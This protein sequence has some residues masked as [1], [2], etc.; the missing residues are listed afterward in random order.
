MGANS[1][2]RLLN[3]YPEV[4]QPT[5]YMWSIA[6]DVLVGTA[7]MEHVQRSISLGFCM[8]GEISYVLSGEVSS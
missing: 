8:A 1:R 4:L 6:F 7:Q 3:K 2:V 5:S